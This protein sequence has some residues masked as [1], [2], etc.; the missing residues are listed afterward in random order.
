M[1]HLHDEKASDN[2]DASRA[3]ECSKSV[4]SAGEELS[5]REAAE[6]A[7]SKLLS[8]AALAEVHGKATADDSEKGGAPD[9]ASNQ[10]AHPPPP[11]P[12]LA[13]RR[14]SYEN[15]RPPMTPGMSNRWGMVGHPAAH[16]PPGYYRPGAMHPMYTSPMM[17]AA[18]RSPSSG[19]SPDEA[20]SRGSAGGGFPMWSAAP[21][22]PPYHPHMHRGAPSQLPPAFRGHMPPS[23]MTRQS[24]STSNDDESSV[25]SARRAA[26]K[27][28]AMG[29]AAKSILKKPRLETSPAATDSDAGKIVDDATGEDKQAHEAS[30]DSVVVEKGSIASEDAATKKQRIISPASSNDSPK[31][32]DEDQVAVGG[33]G[34]LSPNHRTLSYDSSSMGSPNH[35][36]S[37]PPFRMGHPHPAAHGLH[38]SAHHPGRPYMPPSPVYHH[39]GMR[40]FPVAGVRPGMY[41]PPRNM[42]ARGR[43]RYPGMSP[44][45]ARARINATPS[46]AP[47]A[48]EQ[49]RDESTLD[50][51]PS[52]TR[53]A[54]PAT[55]IKRQSPTLRS[56]EGLSDASG[57]STRCIPLAPPVSSKFRR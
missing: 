23:F 9:A 13:M 33:E 6:S 26:P 52:L 3:S 53:S 48:P 43:P 49:Q 29:P 22:R 55:A 54:S 11:S 35:P 34:A 1:P 18:G 38:P 47:S 20:L 15:G 10:E 44:F 5:A 51:S 7:A 36:Y 56:L 30:V 42:S 39:H 57:T 45:Y 50:K 37:A 31:S 8:L 32:E 40:P 46:P 16:F 17:A 25:A 4:H 12:S 19:G 27:R 21:P 24:S 14:P 41:P 28:A 2:D